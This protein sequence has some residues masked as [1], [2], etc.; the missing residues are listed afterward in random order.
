MH[1]VHT[2]FCKNRSTTANV[3]ADGQRQT[4]HGHPFR[5]RSGLKIA[6][7]PSRPSSDVIS[8]TKLFV[9]VNSPCLFILQKKIHH[10]PTEFLTKPH[11]EDLHNL[12]PSPSIVIMIKSRM[13]RWAGHVARTGEK[14][15]A[16]RN[17]VGKTEIKRPRGGHR[18]KWKYNIK[19]E[20]RMD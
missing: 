1:D 3:Q 13:V 4:Q 11:N 12:Y 2:K 9:N 14:R 19:R 20:L 6:A 18:H 8:R 15:N 17:F 16:Y 7:P 5:K 10:I